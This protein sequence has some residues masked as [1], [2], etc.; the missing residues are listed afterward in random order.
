MNFSNL[1]A[2]Y[3]TVQVG[4]PPANVAPTLPVVSSTLV[5]VG[6]ATS[7]ASAKTPST[8]TSAASSS[9]SSKSPNAA[10]RSV[11]NS[12]V[13]LAVAVSVLLTSYMSL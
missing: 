2:M 8:T 3:F 1:Q 13:P 9:Q 12:V 10:T 4:D 6:P 5:P 11:G 7:T